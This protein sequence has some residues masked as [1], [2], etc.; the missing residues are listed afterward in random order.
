[1]TFG[2]GDVPLEKIVAEDDS[3]RLYQYREWR[4]GRETP[5]AIVLV[6]GKGPHPKIEELIHA[7]D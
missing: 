3:I 2:L 7:Q 6:G 4:A 5:H 1:M